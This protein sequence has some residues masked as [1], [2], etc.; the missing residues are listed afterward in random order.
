MIWDDTHNPKMQTWMSESEW[1][2]W[3]KNGMTVR[4]VGIFI[5][6][7]NDFVRLIADID[8]V[9]DD[10]ET[11]YSRAINIGKKLIKEIHVLRRAK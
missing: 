7:D 11:I 6:S 8:L 4:S 1:E 3:C 9:K 10:E 2:E 5:N